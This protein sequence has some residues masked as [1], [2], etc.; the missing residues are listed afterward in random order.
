[1][2]LLVNVLNALTLAR[3][4]PA[5]AAANAQPPLSCVPGRASTTTNSDKRATSSLQVNLGSQ[6]NHQYR[7]RQ[8][9]LGVHEKDITSLTH[10]DGKLDYPIPS[11]FS[12]TAPIPIPRPPSRDP[13]QVYERLPREIRRIK[14]ALPYIGPPS[15]LPFMMIVKKTVHTS[16]LATCKNV[17]K[18]SNGNVQKAI[19]KFILEDTPKVFV[20]SK[21]T[22]CP[23]AYNTLN[24]ILVCMARKRHDLEEFGAYAATLLGPLAD[25]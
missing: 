22:C 5:Y 18:E 9:R 17:S 10:R 24:A 11:S 19:R 13:P 12:T 2:D 1:M 4:T 7:P 6:S 14:V 25:T 20:G 21:W 3:R 23:C 8:T 16:I 15:K